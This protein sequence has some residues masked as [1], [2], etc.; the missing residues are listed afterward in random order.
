MPNH[1]TSDDP[2]H[3]TLN[4][5]DRLMLRQP[6]LHHNEPNEPI[7]TNDAVETIDPSLLTYGTQGFLPQHTPQHN[8]PL[9]SLY[10]PEERYHHR[11]SPS[12]SVADPWMGVG[13][14]G[15]EAPVPVSTPISPAMST[16]VSAFTCQSAIVLC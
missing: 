11:P 6:P 5:P 10:I 2:R 14:A 9:T 16:R 8:P 1:L 15:E 13:Y 7:G 4:Y 12:P 3:H